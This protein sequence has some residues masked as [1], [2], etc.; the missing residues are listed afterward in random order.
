MLETLKVDD[1]MVVRRLNLEYRG[2][3]WLFI[4]IMLIILRR[5]FH[6]ISRILIT[7]TLTTLAG[8]SHISNLLLS[9]AKHNQR[10]GLIYQDHRS[11]LLT[12]YFSNAAVLKEVLDKCWTLY[13]RS[14]L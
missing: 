8:R 9:F 10:V 11:I 14:L 1:K 6:N 13:M 5:V 7:Y 2:S 12:F 3:Y 4:Y